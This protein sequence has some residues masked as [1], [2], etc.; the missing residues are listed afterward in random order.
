MARSSR[1]SKA[2]LFCPDCGHR[3]GVDGDWTV[4]RRHGAAEFVCP[5]CGA[6]IERRPAFAERSSRTL[7]STVGR[8]LAVAA[9]TVSAPLRLL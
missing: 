5:V 8:S 3:S 9:R 6:V 4:S 2:V 7:A 1:P